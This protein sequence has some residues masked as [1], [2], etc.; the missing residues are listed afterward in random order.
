MTGTPPKDL[1]SRGEMLRMYEELLEDYEE[2]LMAVHGAKLR[3]WGDIH[4]MTLDKIK[5]MKKD[6]NF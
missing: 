2:L 1:P 6:E 5:E 4:Q 3:C